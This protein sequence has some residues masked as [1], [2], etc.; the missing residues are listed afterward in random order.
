M[1]DLVEYG[2][3]NPGT[4]NYAHTGLGG[5]PHLAAEL[6]MLRTGAKITGVSYRG[7]GQSVAAVLGHVVDLTFENTSILV[8]LIRDG[9]L[10]AL[11]AQNDTRTPL[12]PEL[13]IMAE[14]GV[15]DCEAKTFFG[16]VAPFGT[17]AA[18]ID[19]V[20]AAMNEGLQTPDIQAAGRKCRQSSQAKLAHGVCQFHRR[21]IS[22][23]GGSEQS[24]APAHRLNIFLATSRS[25]WRRQTTLQP[26]AK[27]RC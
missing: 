12:L 13:P 15:P 23:M 6:F 7:G 9:K 26:R 21:A 3:A 11:A 4:I 8:P 2:I 1:K 24:G 27:C 20:N 18:I 5:L 14:A 19:R 22:K 17:P 16:L 10:R 25:L